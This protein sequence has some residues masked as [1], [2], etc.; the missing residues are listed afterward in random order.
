MLQNISIRFRLTGWYLL[1]VTLIFGVMGVGSWLAMR[2][3]MYGAIDEELDHRIVNLHDF[4]AAHPTSTVDELRGELERAAQLTWGGGLFQVFAEDGSLVFQSEGLARHGVTTLAP[5]MEGDK[6]TH[7]NMEPMD[8]PVRLGA[9]RE[10]FS[11]KTWIVEVGEPLNFVAVSLRDFSRLLLLAV[12]VLIV[13]GTLASYGISGR[14][15]AP[16]DWIIRDA[17]S[18]NSGNLSERLSLPPAHDEL[19]RLSE[20]LNSMLDRIERSVRHIQQFTAD[21][22]HELRSPLTLIRTAAEYA[23]R[24]E[25]SREEL[26]EAMARI[27]RESE[28][29]THLINDLLL[30]TRADANVDLAPKEPVCLASTI[31][32]VMER[33]AP[34]A[35]AQQIGMRSDGVD[36]NVIVLGG[37]QLLERLVYILLDNALKYTGAGGEVSVRLASRNGEAILTVSDSGIGISASD[38]PHLFDRFW[39]A[40]KV[41]SRQEGGSGLGLSIAQKIAEQSGGQIRVESEVGSGSR[42]VV[43]L[44]LVVADAAEGSMHMPNSDRA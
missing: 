34:L 39:R 13:M 6:A 31:H 9:R 8:W 24:R 21:A 40:D 11:G 3:S 27:Q 30:L 36:A 16:V 5:R 20:T 26:T 19:R 15:L 14:A 22:S 28:R 12:P 44:P 18:I 38:L 37:P 4:C 43:T 35:V 29:S 10:S 1:S 17:R 25:R 2:A 23:L 33:I 42:F 41:R 7:R 32:D